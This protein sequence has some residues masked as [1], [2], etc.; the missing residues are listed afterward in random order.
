MFGHVVANTEILSEDEKNIYKSHYCGLC[1]ALRC[2]HG[3][4]ARFALA[5]DMNFLVLLLSS[6]YEPESSRGEERCALHPLKAHAFAVSEITDYA[7]DMNLCLAYLNQLDDWRDDRKLTALLFVL[8]FGRK[9]RALAREY[10]RQCAAMKNGIR[11][12]SKLEASRTCDPD[13]GARIFGAIMGEVFV[14][15]EDRWSDVLRDMAFWLGS[16]IYVMDAVTDLDRDTKRRRFNPLADLKR[17]GKD[18]TFHREIL[19]ML[20]GNCTMEFEKL[21]L[22]EHVSILR[23]VLYSGVWSKFP[24]GPV[25]S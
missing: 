21:P 9:Y 22:V 1:R 15:R 17:Q 2:R 23:N 20:I 16:F 4:A 13:A 12:L 14:M 19:T 18:E 5:Y 3:R 8:R 10:P 7:A 25:P 6:L 24:G 11:E